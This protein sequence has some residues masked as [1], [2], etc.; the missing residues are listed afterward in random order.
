MNFSVYHEVAHRLFA[1]HANVRNMR[2][3]FS[4]LRSKFETRIQ[5]G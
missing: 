1:S 2:S 3:F 4:V 5:L